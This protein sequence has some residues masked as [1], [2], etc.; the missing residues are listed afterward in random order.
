M[1][2]YRNTK[3][4]FEFVSPCECK[5]EGWTKVS[6]G[7]LSNE[8]TETKEVESPKKTAKRTTKNDSDGRRPYRKV[9]ASD[10]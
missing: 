10:N 2:T 9:E 4:G 7:S 3:T 8:P 5:G 6:S 1:N